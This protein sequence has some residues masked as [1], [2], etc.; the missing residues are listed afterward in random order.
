MDVGDYLRIY[1]ADQRAVQAAIVRVATR[2]ARSNR[3]TPWS[4]ELND[5]AR[6]V[7]D[8]AATLDSVAGAC[9][10]DGGAVKRILS[11]AA[12]RIGRLKLNGHLLTYSPLS[13]VV[14][15]EGLM[16]ALTL[17]REMWLLLG[18]L[19]DWHPPLA[20]FDFGGLVQRASAQIELLR[21]IHEWAADQLAARTGGSTPDRVRRPRRNRDR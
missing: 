7:E 21:P 14:E 5:L 8:D 6:E 17:K 18:R 13:R 19:Q 11:L 4:R 9:G 12:E 2:F 1:L 16:A 10:A 3:S 20:A 15:T